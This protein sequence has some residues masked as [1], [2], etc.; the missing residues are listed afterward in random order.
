MFEVTHH[1]FEVI[2]LQR[3]PDMFVIYH[4]VTSPIPVKFL[5]SA[6]TNRLVKI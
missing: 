1:L 6:T 2:I 5:F 3:G 4:C